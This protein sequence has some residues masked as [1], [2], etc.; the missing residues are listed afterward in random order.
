MITNLFA[1]S[2]KQLKFYHTGYR[3]KSTQDLVLLLLFADDAVL[4]AK[5]FATKIEKFRG[6]NNKNLTRVALV[7]R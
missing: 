7:Q 6:G 5:N 3:F 1:D 4:I 2:I